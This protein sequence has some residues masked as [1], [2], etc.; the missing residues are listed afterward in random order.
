M[1]Y[2]DSC[3]TAY[4]LLGFGIQFEV[5]YKNTVIGVEVLFLWDISECK[6]GKPV[7][8]FYVYDG[9]SADVL[10]SLQASILTYVADN[11]VIFEN[12]SVDP[13]VCVDGLIS[14]LK[15]DYSISAS[16]FL[17]FGNEDFKDT[18]SYCQDFTSVDGSLGKWKGGIAYSPSC[19]TVSVGRTILGGNLL[20]S[21][22]V[23][24]TWYEKVAVFGARDNTTTTSNHNKK[25]GR[26]FCAM[27]L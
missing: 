21:W 1:K 7:V 16:G 19:Y 11:T 20:S 27:L 9:V 22:S 17:V 4:S 26:S 6:E 25:G 24:K 8:A 3:G 2:V 18:S 15:S 5:E 13:L 12:G 10:D 23:S 14:M